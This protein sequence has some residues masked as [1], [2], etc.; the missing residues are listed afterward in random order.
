MFSKRRQ[1]QKRKYKVK[2]KCQRKDTQQQVS[3]KKRKN[4]QNKAEDCI[5]RARHDSKML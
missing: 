2:E 4:R 3:T 1:N 5:D